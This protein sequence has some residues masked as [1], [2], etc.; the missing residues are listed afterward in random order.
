MT[1]DA[2]RTMPQPIFDALD[3]V[4]ETFDGNFE[5]RYGFDPGTARRIDQAFLLLEYWRQECFRRS[6]C[7]PPRSSLSCESE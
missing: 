2:E 4:L 6:G 3:L 1:D 5:E 7:T